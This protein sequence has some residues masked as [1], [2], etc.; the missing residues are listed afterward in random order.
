[1][2]DAGDSPASV[3]A[4]APA[5]AAPVAPV[6]PTAPPLPA[7]PALPN[8]PEWLS[9]RLLHDKGVISDAELA[10]ALA[11]IGVVG[12]GDATTLVVSKL[13]VTLY[14]YLEG[15]YKYDSTQTCVEF[16]GSTQVPRSDTY[17]GSHG[18]TIFSARDSRLGLRIA[19]PEHHGVR[20]SGV[21]E[22]DFFGRRRPPSNRSTRTRSSASAPRT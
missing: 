1:V 22:T 10:S 19:A 21:L 17:K 18:R 8:G 13:K 2:P 14:G 20:V 4:G 12:G 3:P 16:C 7:I 11:D 15:N 9:L 6:V 5:T